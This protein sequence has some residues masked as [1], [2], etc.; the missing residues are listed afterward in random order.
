MLRNTMYLDELVKGRYGRKI[1]YY[2]A[3]RID[4]SNALD[5]ISKTIGVFNYNKPIIRYLWRYKN[6]D[7]PIRYRQKIVRDD[8]VNTI[9]ENHAWEIVAFKTAQ[10]YGEPIQIVSLD[11]EDA[12]SKASAPNATVRQVSN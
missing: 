7:Q 4:E 6:G 5:A 12:I 1:A 10:T 3:D 9:V 11:K 2:D 8:I